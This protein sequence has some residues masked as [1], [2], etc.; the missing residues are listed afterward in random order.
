MSILKP[1]QR[2]VTRVLLISGVAIINTFIL[3]EKETKKKLKGTNT[4]TKKK[5]CYQV[6]NI[7]TNPR[8]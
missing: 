4:K 3:K 8:T 7:L 5:N 6:L 1:E 2:Q